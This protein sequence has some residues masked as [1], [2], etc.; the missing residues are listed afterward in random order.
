MRVTAGGWAWSL[1]GSP[2]AGVVGG[3]GGSVQDG[4]LP[5][6]GLGVWEDDGPVFQGGVAWGRVGLGE[7]RGWG[8]GWFRAVCISLSWPSDPRGVIRQVWALSGLALHWIAGWKPPAVDL[9]FPL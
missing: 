8:G 9:L 2:R 1:Q 5:A 6:C 3:M 4:C 7:F